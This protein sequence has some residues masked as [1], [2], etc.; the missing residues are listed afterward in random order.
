MSKNSYRKYA[1]EPSEI[2]DTVKSFRHV[3]SNIDSI[4]ENLDFK[5]SLSLYE[6]GQIENLHI[7][8]SKL[9][10]KFGKRMEVMEVEFKTILED[11]KDGRFSASDLE[12]LLQA[13]QEKGLYALESAEEVSNTLDVLFGSLTQLLMQVQKSDSAA[14]IDL[15]TIAAVAAQL[16]EAMGSLNT[17]TKVAS[18]SPSDIKQVLCATTLETLSKEDNKGKFLQLLEEMAHLSENNDEIGVDEAVNA[19]NQSEFP[20][21][22]EHKVVRSN[23]LQRTLS[24]DSNDSPIIFEGDEAGDDDENNSLSDIFDPSL[25]SPSH[26]L[27]RVKSNLRLFSEGI[28]HGKLPLKLLNPHHGKKCVTSRITSFNISPESDLNIINAPLSEQMK[29]SEISQGQEASILTIEDDG[30]HGPII[31]NIQI[32]PHK[33]MKNISKKPPIRVNTATTITNHNKTGNDHKT[34]PTILHTVDRKISTDKVL[35]SEPIAL[36]STSS[37]QTEDKKYLEDV[38]KA[39]RLLIALTVKEETLQRLEESLHLR[40]IQIE[41]E[42]L[43]RQKTQETMYLSRRQAME[44]E[45]MAKSVVMEQD[46][47]CRR[48]LLEKEEKK[49]RKLIDMSLKSMSVKSL[50]H[51]IASITSFLPLTTQSP[52]PPPQPTNSSIIVPEEIPSVITKLPITIEIDDKSKKSILSFERKTMNRPNKS[53]NTKSITSRNS[54]QI[55]FTDRTHLSPNNKN[56]M[57]TI[58]IISIDTKSKSTDTNDLLTSTTSALVNR[59]E[60]KISSISS[61]QPTFSNTTQVLENFHVIQNPLMTLYEIYEKL[62]SNE[63]KVR[64]LTAASIEASTGAL[65][66]ISKLFKA[67][68]DEIIRSFT[69]AEELL[70]RVTSASDILNSFIVLVGTPVLQEE[71]FIATIERYF[72]DLGTF[73]V[74]FIHLQLQ[75]QEYRSI[76][77]SV[78]VSETTRLPAILK[79]CPD[80]SIAYERYVDYQSKLLILNTK[81][82]DLKNRT[83]RD[84]HFISSNH[85]QQHQQQQQQHH[86]Q[87]QR[88]ISLDGFISHQTSVRHMSSRPNTSNSFISR[89]NTSNGSLLTKGKTKLEVIEIQL[90]D[91]LDEIDYLERSLFEAQQGN[92]RT[93]GALLFFAAMNDE[94]TIPTIQQL[95]LQLS[96]LKVATDGANRLDYPT[97][98]KRLQVA[99]DCLP[100][101]EKFITRYSSMHYKWTQDRIKVFL[102]LKQKGGDADKFFVCPLCCMDG[103]TVCTSTNTSTSNTSGSRHISSSINSSSLPSMTSDANSLMKRQ[104]SASSSSLRRVGISQGGHRITKL[105]P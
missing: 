16:D 31:D 59:E 102:S 66:M 71:K 32:K 52:S 48:N 50:V 55:P 7:K 91:A 10:Q 6:H 20:L 29:V 36:T 87:Q 1:E 86:H 45:M 39:E 82:V 63:S 104:S 9:M 51:I 8:T 62:L 15:S 95:I 44:D 53:L 22:K 47:V 54:S 11:F 77:E 83:D 41:E 40:Q 38:A 99:V 12:E 61:V 18:A 34:T 100:I 17:L 70:I 58:R 73:Q 69:M 92:D 84:L 68:K 93:P 43:V 21:K 65:P 25:H 75:L 14:H 85:Q 105:L 98:V 79:T 76:F 5:T 42:L 2:K 23:R 60:V 4:L 27:V 19:F 89:P 94:N 24:R 80:A 88:Y 57:E 78:S 67:V 103:R 81:I 3:Q 33:T 35:A 49:L 30:E 90:K 74:S 46:L 72:S 56:L 101:L 97:L 96:R 26:T 37:S 28:K 13:E 64:L